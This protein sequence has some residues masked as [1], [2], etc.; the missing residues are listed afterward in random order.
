MGFMRKAAFLS[1]GGLSRAAG[2]KLN[3]TDERE[4]KAAEKSVKIQ[5][6]LLKEQRRATRAGSE[7]SVA[8]AVVQPVAIAERDAS[9]SGIAGELERLA[10]L[11]QQGVLTESEFLAA[12]EKLLGWS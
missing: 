7:A 2:L 9:G 5:K 3:S 1:T 10:A 11:R 6:Q 12:K 4:A 8:A